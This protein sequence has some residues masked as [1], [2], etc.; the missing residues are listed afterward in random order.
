MPPHLKQCYGHV[1]MSQIKLKL[2]FKLKGSLLTIV[3]IYLGIV[4]NYINEQ[5]AR[6]QS[7]IVSGG[8]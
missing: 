1:R 2:R 6:T 7:S 8:Y 5:N 4:S 3:K